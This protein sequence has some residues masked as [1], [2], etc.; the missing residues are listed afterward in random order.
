MEFNYKRIKPGY[1][2]L[3]IIAAL[4]YNQVTVKAPG[5]VVFLNT[6]WYKRKYFFSNILGRREQSS[7][8]AWFHKC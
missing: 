1:F 4:L 3:A 7:R 2:A 8:R 5:P 6:T